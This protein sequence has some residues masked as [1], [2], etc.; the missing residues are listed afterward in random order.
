M[1]EKAEIYEVHGSVK[2]RDGIP[3]RG[4][5]VAVWWQRIRERSEL[6]AGAT[7]EDGRYYLRYHVPENAP[8]PLLIVI[9]ALSEHLDEP[10]FS[11]LTE[12]QKKLE[13]DLSYEP[14]DQ[15]EWASLVRSVEP[16]LGD[17]KLSEL[18]ESKTH[19]DISFLARELGKDTETVMRVA[20]AA[21]LGEAFKIPAPAFYAFLRQHVPA[22]LPSPLLDAS[23]N[24]TLIDALVQTIGS[25]IFGLSAEVQ[26]QTLTAA[27]A[28][29]LIGS[30]FT[31]QV[32]KLVNDLQ[33]H[34]TSDLLNQPN[35]AGNASLAQLLDVAELA[36]AKQQ[37]FAQ[38]LATNTQTMRGFWRTLGD[39]KHGFTA[40]EASAA[41][42]SLTIGAFVRNFVPLMQN[43]VQGFASG[44]YQA[45]PDL[46]RLS[47]QDWI[48]MVE[49]TGPPPG[50]E[51][52]AEASP[53]QVFASIVYSRVTRAYPTAAL[54]SRIAGG[55]LVPQ[56]Q[57]QPLTQFFQNNPTVE[58]IQHNIPAYLAANP[59]AFSGIS[60]DD[61]AAVVAN[62]R[63]FQRVLRVA[64]S[65][66]VAQALLGLGITS[67]TQIAAQGQQQF[68]TKVTAAGVTAAE[69]DQAFQAATQRY[70]N[71]VS[72]YLQL[73]KDSIGLWPQ[74]MGQLSALD[75]AEQQAIRRDPTLAT[76][77][78]SQDYC[79]TDDCTS[80]LS[81][82]AYLCDL[83][84][85]LRN[86][87][88]GARTALDVLDDRR[89]D[90]RHLLLNCPNTDTELPYIDLVNELL[91]D[92]ISP[93]IDSIA[94]SYT[95]AALVNGTTYYYLMTAVNEV[96]ES[97]ASAQA[98]ATPAAA[99]AAP[100]APAGVTATPGDAQVT[101][102]WDPV[103]DATS[104]N[105]YW[106]TTAG[107]TTATGTK[108]TGAANP[109]IQA[110]LVN[111]TTYYYL[112]TAVNEVGESAASAQASAT[113][114]AATAA[115]AAPAGVTAT[116]GDAQVTIS[117][118]P[119]ADAT[120]Y[121]LYW[122]TTAGITTATG[123][124]ITGAANPYIQAALVNGTTY[125]YL[126]TAVNE[127]GESAAS[128]Q[129][130]ATP[131][132]A[133]AAPA[134]PAGVTATPGD[135]Q[136]TISWDPVADAT[137]YNLYWSTTAGIT[138]ATGTKI[139]GSWNPQW[140]QTSANRTTAEL[141][142]APEYFN[143]GAYVTLFGASYP[144]TLP[145]SAGLD[146]LRT[147]LQQLKLPLWQLRQALL[148]LTDATG[149][150]L[151]A[152]AAER[153]GMPPH[154]EDLVANQDFVPAP[155]AWN[156]A[157]PPTDLVPVPAFLQAASLTYES[158]LEL[159][160]VAW[161][162]DGLGVTIQ[163]LNDTCDTSIQTLGPSPLDAGFLDRA[164]RFL[165]LWLSTGYKMWELDLLLG[166]EDIAVD[167][168][169]GP[170]ALAALLSF[171]Q[172][173]D[174]THLA[175]DRQL[176][177]YQNIDTATHRDP[178]G[179]TTTSL[180]A[181]IF[182]NPA[183]T[184]VAPDPDLMVLPTGG[185]IADP[186]L[187]DHLAAIQAA[188]GVSGAD[189]AT[190]FGLTDNQLTL[191]NLS[192]IYRVSALAVASRFSI[193]DLI[194]VAK[195]L[196]A[197]A[198]PADALAPLFASPAATLAFLSQAA[199]IQKSGLS[200]DA[201]T[202]LLT[203]PPATVLTA[204]ITATQT[205]ITVASDT[206]FPP[207]N[208]YISVG[209]ETMLVTAV[210]G[211]GNTTWTVERGQQG[212]TAA[213][214]TNGAAV[215]LTAGWATTTQMIQAD[216]ATALG[217]VRQAVTA[218]L[219]AST[220]LAAPI[221][222]TQTSITVAS[223][224]GFPAPDF[225][226]AIGSELLL[227]TA[228]GGVGN[229]TW[230]VERGY[231]GTTPA[232]AA[233]GAA[234]TPTGGDVNGAVIAAVAANAHKANTAPLANDVTAMVLNTL[235]IP[236]T[237]QTLLAALADPAFTG[238]SSQI[239][240][241]NFAG[242]F[243]AIQ[244]FDK[245]AVLVR[246]LHLVARDLTWLLA[247]AAV[248]GGL[249]LT[250]LP[251]APSQPTQ[252]LSPL[253]TTLLVIKLARLWTAAP[254][255]SPVQTL[256]DIIGSI[257]AGTLANETA[258]QTALATITGWPLADIASF[259]TALGLAFPGGYEA[260]A[261]YDA[262]R[263]LEA[264]ASA[265]GATGAQIVNWGTVPP[266]ETTAEGAADGVLAVLKAQQ[267]SNEA[268]LALAPTLMN[269]IRDRR[270]AALRADLIAQ[271]DSSGNLIYGDP[272]GLFDYFLIDVQMTSCQLTSRVVQAYI[273]L[274]IFVERCLMNLEAP[275]VVA[276]NSWSQWEWMSR[277]RIWEAN[278]EVFL[279]PENWLIESQRPDRTEIYQK[280][281]QEVHQGQ[282]T[283]DYLET[284]VLNYID[285][286]D[287][288]AHLQVTGT[289]EDPATGT[290]HVVARTLADPP[291]YYHRSYVNGAWTG[292]A[293]IPLD[294]KAPQAVPALY[295]DELCL[296]WLDVKVSNEPQQSL[297]APQQSAS[298][299]PQN[300]ERYVAL[301]VYFSTFRDGAWAPAQRSKGKLF[302]KPL[303]DPTKANNSSNV[304]SLYSVRVQ[305]PAAT[306]GYGANLWV[307]VFRLGDYQVVT[308]D[309][310]FSASQLRW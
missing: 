193:S 155:V 76:L 38:A 52:T 280:L 23:Q 273:A 94:T 244:L 275:A 217:A 212:T 191:A 66:D 287:G 303:L 78:G 251:V 136:V 68:S 310:L 50:V 80:I 192:F 276:D 102:S 105:L 293:Q 29:D 117:W 131:A 89:P 55:A 211:V 26:S 128:A 285:R 297:P 176:A 73:N 197:A 32:S 93:P 200:L 184:S 180:Y 47:K 186:V 152:V 135:A 36:P 196:T 98:S 163:G 174:A 116:P 156:T 140:K 238:S 151:A 129:A 262:L 22:A 45:L 28:L 115:P 173:Q 154:A 62:T 149:A 84:L 286:L 255:A 79:A 241:A 51:A 228:V 67:A 306:P 96:G 166:S 142:A 101:I 70:A 301:G 266:D 231:Q 121:N 267:P 56:P 237:T 274:Q 157:N 82:A 72:L 308:R 139:T 153:F 133:T 48:Q 281:E 289:C 65:V 221:D 12:A 168:I 146:E 87:P 54:S 226:V 114:A 27:I 144:F 170:G 235:Q 229:T 71:V 134:A 17:L 253:L 290:I 199:T 278:R 164:H 270:S 92:K 64:P 90:I 106:S 263:T 86:R 43:L 39:G 19:Q 183:V 63:S 132:A 215:G 35:L 269:P 258:A 272:D 222:N 279:Y 107:I 225:T 282:S 305:T 57:Q 137:S 291:V 288:V 37:A 243:L 268:W 14:P 182:L 104:Y 4:A 33:A 127:V 3:L 148:P 108:I 205:S 13:I 298:P 138:T 97:A 21:R 296:F 209:S 202:Y 118:D 85:W 7:S 158:L 247:S 304:A 111:G 201:L 189:A 112:M 69:A 161:V 60:E 8:L 309:S 181:Q 239:T 233:T 257:S 252:S 294:I 179:T 240:P 249:D 292:W 49:Q 171:R 230:T 18:V 150:E 254:P 143:Q 159:L 210:G 169:L 259:G 162:Q 283:T 77:F 277:Y 198:N 236:G 1:N 227:V 271:R 103:A 206:G 165:R 160:Q 246:A 123:T 9:E 218:L 300:V 190:L 245:V 83:L 256:Y 167:G 234:V 220:A 307:D 130:S 248:Y 100:A 214:A 24:F 187:S 195:L 5:R 25:L 219:A 126:M 119:V 61:R 110:A 88:A 99:T 194:T 109:Y 261:S 122:S 125:Y 41:E 172:L 11:A 20:V 16:L 216:I 185:T 58:L 44:T 264:M 75:E 113:P 59:N 260:P 81:P 177:F 224:A 223:D 204:D 40:A 34:H 175:V 95:Q 213:A 299:P 42:R 208:F 178:D 91:A 30:Q 207:L 242:Q 2:G 74:A 188:L 46:A 232:A 295:R 124:K 31:K 284:V 250:Q 15:S 10:L 120:S 6:T 53:A 302:D 203:P 265:A 147:Y 141:S 145:Y